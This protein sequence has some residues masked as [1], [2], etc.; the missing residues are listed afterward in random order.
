VSRSMRPVTLHDDFCNDH[1]LNSQFLVD[2]AGKIKVLTVRSKDGSGRR[3]D[4]APLCRRRRSHTKLHDVQV[5]NS[6]TSPNDVQ[7]E[8]H[9]T[10]LHDVQVEKSHTSLND[11]LVD[12]SDTSLHDV[13]A[14]TPITQQGLQ[15]QKG[16]S[17]NSSLNTTPT[18]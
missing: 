6:H 3:P 12:R 16:D 5:E 7:V 2:C 8:K 18:H 4:I 17:G 10:S 9:R 14:E 13:Q 15:F 11:V 1:S